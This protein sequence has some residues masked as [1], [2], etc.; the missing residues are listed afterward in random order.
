MTTCIPAGS[1][2]LH[3]SV[4]P[5]RGQDYRKTSW[6]SGVAFNRCIQKELLWY[7]IGLEINFV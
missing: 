7:V 3:C 2:N 1:G 6:V 5:C 4:A